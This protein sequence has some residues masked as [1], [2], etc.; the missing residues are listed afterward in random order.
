MTTQLS[1]KRV[2]LAAALACLILIAW[3]DSAPARAR[4]PDHP[5]VVF[6][7]DFGTVD[8][9]VAVCKGVMFGV[10][11]SLR[12]VDITHEVT[13]YSILD[14][15]RFLAGTASYFGPGTVFVGVVDPGVGSPRK[16]VVVRTKRGQF[17]VLPDN[18]LVTLVADRDGVEAAR[19]IANPEW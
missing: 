8:D 4:K 19:E 9:S 1:S 16:A 10:E 7:S 3:A 12:I 2:R 11:P 14:G 6:L 17:F 18:G 5:T 15:A 13:P